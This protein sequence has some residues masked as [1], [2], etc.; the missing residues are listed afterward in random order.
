VIELL[1]A[2]SGSFMPYILAAGALLATILGAYFKGKA[3]E[4]AKNAIEQAEARERYRK[5][6]D[7][8]IRRADDARSRVPDG[9]QDDD[10]YLRD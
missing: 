1:T 10:P 9:L 5:E 8:A 2:L 6:Q 4:R 3:N 7:D